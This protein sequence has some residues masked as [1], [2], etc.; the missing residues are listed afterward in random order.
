MS[1]VDKR[2]PDLRYTNTKA[3]EAEERVEQMM[4]AYNDDL[5][6]LLT[7]ARDLVEHI[8]ALEDVLK[9]YVEQENEPC[10]FDHHGNCQEHGWFIDEP[11]EVCGVV[12]GR[13]LLG[14]DT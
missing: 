1:A 12:R 9:G 5:H 6:S 2:G 4:R 13:K 8:D 11:G 14:L 10:W 7:W 3:R